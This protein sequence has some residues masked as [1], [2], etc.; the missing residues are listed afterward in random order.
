MKK[1]DKKGLSGVVTMLI[2]ILIS[3]VAISI[4]WVV[5][6][7]VISKGVEDV[8]LSKYTLN[9]N[10]EKVLM[11]PGNV[12][13]TVKRNVG[14]GEMAGISFILTDG[15]NSQVIE[16]KNAKLQELEVKTFSV[17]YNG[18]VKQ[19]VIAPILPTESGKGKTADAADIVKFT[20]VEAVKN[21]QGLVSWWRFE[22]NANDEM[23]RNNGNLV[24]ANLTNADGNAPPQPIQ[25]KFGQGYKFDGLDDYINVSNNPSLDITN[26]ITLVV[27]AYQIPG[28]NN[29]DKLLISKDDNTNPNTGAGSYTLLY[30]YGN[31]T[32]FRTFTTIANS[33]TATS[34]LPA[35]TWHQIA[36]TYN[37]SSMQMYHNGNPRG[38]LSTSGSIRVSTHSL[39]IGGD[40]DSFEFYNPFNGTL[41]EVMIFNRSLTA[42][43]IQSLYTF[44]IS[45]S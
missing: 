2:I 30:G 44:D 4:V 29:R 37:G 45:S 1:S 6:R 14:R 16:D 35:Y 19:V 8:S 23:G 13:V 17:P 38:Q 43:E 7:N 28:I 12:D 25:G 26:E 24:D 3:L 42:G 10:I 27:W 20:G 39:K 15:V 40:S 34:T 9:L 41:D 18:I 36:S 22:G 33:L 31:D 21:M 11:K 32:Y 5:I